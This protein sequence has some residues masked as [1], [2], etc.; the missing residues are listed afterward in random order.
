MRY[1]L[2]LGHLVPERVVPVARTAERCGFDGV[3]MSDHVVDLV[4]VA[5]QYPYGGRSTTSAPRPRL[6]PWVTAGLVVAATERLTFMTSVYVLTLRHPL[7]TA[8]AA[9]TVARASGG[10]LILGLGQGWLREE[11]ESLGVPFER[12]GKRFDEALSIARLMWS[13]ERVAHDGA[14]YRF[15]SLISSP[16]PEAPIPLYVGGHSL[17][18]QERA[19]RWGDGWIC[20]PVPTVITDQIATVR[21]LRAQHGRSETPFEFV[22]MCDDP[23]PALISQLAGAG[24]SHVNVSP[25]WRRAGAGDEIA[26]VESLADRLGLAAAS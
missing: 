23:S 6:D 25:P 3:S 5:S 8:K 11:F 7:L 17:A 22:A 4:E 16:R 10:R 18:M 26:C 1:S 2:S 24:I 13:H 19:A 14:C 20:P 15:P 21:R 12:R 9:A